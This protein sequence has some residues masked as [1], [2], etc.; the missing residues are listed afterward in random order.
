MEKLPRPRKYFSELSQFKILLAVIFFLLQWHEY[1]V[2]QYATHPLDPL[3]S[4]EYASV[5]RIL[6][7][8]KYASESTLYP[9]ITLYE[10]PKAEVWKWKAN[11]PITRK[12]FAIVMQKRAV[13]E[14]VVDISGR[15]VL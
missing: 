13:Y 15:K 5:I 1:S 14:A 4:D 11:A 10:P 6:K 3:N 12:A 8:G 9:L 7:S 2:A